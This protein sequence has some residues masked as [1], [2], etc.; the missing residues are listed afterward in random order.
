[1]GIRDF[2]QYR[3]PA[4]QGRTFRPLSADGWEIPMPSRVRNLDNWEDGVSELRIGIAEEED[5]DYFCGIRVGVAQPFHVPDTHLLRIGSLDLAPA[6][7]PVSVILSMFS[8]SDTGGRE[9]H[10]TLRME[11]SRFFRVDDHIDLP[12]DHPNAGQLLFVTRHARINYM[13]IY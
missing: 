9:W 4:T 2:R 6:I 3:H 11:M 8:S 7:T 5:F 13:V 10:E 1:M 12:P